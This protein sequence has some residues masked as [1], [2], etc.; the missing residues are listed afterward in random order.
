MITLPTA[1]T[2][3]VVVPVNVSSP[4]VA[5]SGANPSVQYYWWNGNNGVISQISLK[6]GEYIINGNS[7]N[8]SVGVTGYDAEAF[9][10]T[11]PSGTKP[12][13]NKV[14]N[15]PQQFFHTL[16]NVPYSYYGENTKIVFNSNNAKLI[17]LETEG[18]VNGNLDNRVTEGL[19][20]SATRD[21][22]REYQ[23]YTGI[24][25]ED[26][27]ELLFVNKGEI[28]IN[29]T[30]SAYFFTTSHTNGN[31]RTNY[32]DNEGTITVL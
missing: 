18:I 4:S 15:V 19:I 23:S 11:T 25:G 27:T 17:D 2:L 10:G 31:Y 5:G 13:E 30:G 21:R 3:P 32:L 9:P 6:S 22:L 26:G 16:L 24:I 20:T 29:G 1:P 8:Y 14:Y 28:E 12:T 7:G